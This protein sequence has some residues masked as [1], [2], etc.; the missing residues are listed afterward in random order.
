MTRP[1]SI[2]LD[3]DKTIFGGEFTSAD[4]VEG[5]PIVGAIEW[6]REQ[7]SAGV[8]ITIHTCRLTPAYPG[9]Y[10][11]QHMDQPRVRTAITTWLERW[12]SADEIAA[13]CWWTYPG[14]PGAQMYLD[15]KGYRFAGVFPVFSGSGI[16]HGPAVTPWRRHAEIELGDDD[17]VRSATD[18]QLR[19]AMTRKIEDQAHAIDVLAELAAAGDV[20]G[21]RMHF[22]HL[23]GSKGRL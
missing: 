10:W 19:R 17:D 21:I 3:F 14:K 4:V 7:L 5:P 2:A 13:L 11:N 16:A 23:K 20:D 8:L 1:K 15:D 12:L 18:E 9:T 22:E 6:L